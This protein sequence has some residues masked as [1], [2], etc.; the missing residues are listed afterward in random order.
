MNK[1]KRRGHTSHCS[2]WTLPCQLK[3]GVWGGTTSQTQP[4]IGLAKLATKSELGF[5]GK[6]LDGRK[7]KNLTPLFLIVCFWTAA[8]RIPESMTGQDR[9]MKKRG[10][11]KERWREQ[12]KETLTACWDCPV[13]KSPHW[14]PL[15]CPKCRYGPA[16]CGEWEKREG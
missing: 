8:E 13:Q 15:L 5:G 6:L 12:K 2:V 1:K 16:P 3:C 4:W 14:C 10:W 7:M 11:E 9:E